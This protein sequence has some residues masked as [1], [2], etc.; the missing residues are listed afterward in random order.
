MPLAVTDSGPRVTLRNSFPN[1]YD[2]AIAAARTC[3]SHRVIRPEEITEKQRR[4]IGSM[5]FEAGHHTVYQH[6]TFEFAL[7]GVS[8]QLVWSFLHSFPFY[9]AE[10][11]SQRYVRMD[12]IAAHVPDLEPAARE[13]Y[14]TAIAGA[15][16]AYDRI[17][18]LLEEP[19][20]ET[21]CRVWRLSTD[22]TKTPLKKKELRKDAGK[23]AI[24]TARYVL[25]VACHTALVYTISGLTLHR[26]RRMMSCS[27]APAEARR[28][29]PLL[30]DA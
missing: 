22:P 16:Q 18:A 17:S 20:Y 7:E 15:W 5:T 13:I 8:R 29:V 9:N 26:L 28:L 10:Q 14:E 4:S 3:Y 2:D 12:E 23:R 19:C 11:Q 1:P 24:E 21:L 30:A 27:D 25:P 6:A